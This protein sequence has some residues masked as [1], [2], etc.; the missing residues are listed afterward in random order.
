MGQYANVAQTF[1][2]L[3]PAVEHRFLCSECGDSAVENSDVKR[4]RWTELF[5]ISSCNLGSAPVLFKGFFLLFLT[6]A[7]S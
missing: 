1:H 2:Q 5:D 7:V 3:N 4:G 6:I